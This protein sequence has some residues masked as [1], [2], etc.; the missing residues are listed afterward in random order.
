MTIVQPPV[1]CSHTCG[2]LPRAR[3][4]VTL[5][6]ALLLAA[7]R[8][9]FDAIRP[10]RALA[11]LRLRP[12]IFL[13][14]RHGAGVADPTSQLACTPQLRARRLTVRVRCDRGAALTAA[15]NIAV[16]SARATVL[17]ESRAHIQGGR[18]G[19]RD[20]G[21]LQRNRAAT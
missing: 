21:D 15:A 6:D 14:A 5:D 11:E 13:W 7:D 3:G 17:Q 12:A 19:E 10:C 1:F 18:T 16:A 4:F 8:E 2:C 20:R 9:G